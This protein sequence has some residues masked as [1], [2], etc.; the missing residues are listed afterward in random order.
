MRQS[1]VDTDTTLLNVAVIP[2]RDVALSVERLSAELAN[3][4]GLFQIDGVHKLAHLT[5]YMA[6]FAKGDLDT[7]LKRIAKVATEFPALPVQ[8]SG[9]FLTPGKYYEA[10]YGRTPELLKL[11][12]S[13]IDSVSPCRYSP[14]KPVREEYFGPYSRGQREQAERYGYD[15]AGE[16]YRPHITIT[17]FSEPPGIELPTA[18]DDLSFRATTI[19][20]YQADSF[21]AVTGQLGMWD[22]VHR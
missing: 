13:I 7:V 20:V 8:H 14:G 22:L 21:G 15:L 4:G 9:Y 2:S 11:H 5:L 10:S 18:G 6:R 17:R 19:G 16:M 1:D 12:H 3:H